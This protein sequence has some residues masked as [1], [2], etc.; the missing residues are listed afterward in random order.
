[1]LR[2]ETHSDML[3][4]SAAA[5][6]LHE[7]AKVARSGASDLYASRSRVRYAV[8]DARTAGFDVGED[9]SVT[10]RSRSGSTAQR[11]ARQAQAQAFAGEIRQRAAQ[12]VR[13][14]QHVAGN[15]TTSVAGI[16]HPFPQMPVRAA[17]PKQNHVQAIDHHWKQ[18]PT[19]APKPEPANGPS[20]DA[21]STVLDKLPAGDQ[22]F[23]REVRSPEDLQNLWKW[24]QQNGEEI[25]NGYGDP[26]KGIRYRLPDGT[27]IGQRWSAES[28]GRPV[29]DI[30][31][32]GERGYTKIHINP[33]GGVPDIPAP[34]SPAPPATPPPRAPVEPPPATRPPAAPAPRRAPPMIGIGPVPPESVPRPVHPPHSHHGPPVLGKDELP[35]LDEFTPG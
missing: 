24:A 31:I 18:D 22:P 28:T 30:D 6:Q 34:V 2:T 15:V 7:A 14:D 21:I 1:M 16:R 32:L 9:L 17:L 29:L 5:D 12:L 25:P 26:N 27:V 11:L 10:D 4:T 20:A 23:I 8:E 3:T 19:P 35:D 33:R 13:L